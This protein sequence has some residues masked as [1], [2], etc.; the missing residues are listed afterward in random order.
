MALY[1][2]LTGPWS[3]NLTV[4]DHKLRPDCVSL[5]RGGSPDSVLENFFIAERSDVRFCRSGLSSS[6]LT[7][8]RYCR[9]QLLTR[10]LTP[11]SIVFRS[12]SK[13]RERKYHSFAPCCCS[14]QPS[15]HRQS[16]YRILLLSSSTVVL[17]I[18]LFLSRTANWDF[19]MTIWWFRFAKSALPLARGHTA[20]LLLFPE[21]ATAVLRNPGPT[22]GANENTFVTTWRSQKH[23]LRGKARPDTIGLQL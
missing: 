15:S 9:W 21:N 23:I 20:I 13:A 19:L 6:L 12:T 3:R 17:H 11:M 7:S 16:P 14:F 8:I 5:S 4:K 22:W 2:L 1:K 18:T 10:F